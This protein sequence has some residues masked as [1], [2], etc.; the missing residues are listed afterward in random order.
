MHGVLGKPCER[1][2]FAIQVL[3][4]EPLHFWTLSTRLGAPCVAP[5]PALRD[6]TGVK[7][8]ENDDV[9]AGQ[10]ALV[11]NPDSS[12]LYTPSETG[13]L[14]LSRPDRAINTVHRAGEL[15]RNA[16][17]GSRDQ[18]ASC[19]LGGLRGAGWCLAGGLG[20]DA[21]RAT[22]RADQLFE[23]NAEGADMIILESAL[24]VV[25]PEM[26]PSARPRSGS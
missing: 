14:S 3:A 23:P 22:F 21:P 12:L 7:L 1:D 26:L 6:A 4:G 10:G 17:R 2:T 9:V 5:V 13:V 15:H 16:G 8:V 18:G 24:R 11:G 25:V 19:P 20:G